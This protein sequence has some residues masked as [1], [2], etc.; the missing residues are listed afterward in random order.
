MKVVGAEAYSEYDDNKE[1]DTPAG[2]Q[3]HWQREHDAA[4]KRLRKYTNQGSRIVARYLGEKSGDGDNYGENREFQLN[5]FHSNIKTLTSMLYGNKPKIDV[6]REHH[7]PDD[8][9]GRVDAMLYQRILEADVAPSGDKISTVLKNVLQDRLLPGMGVARVRYDVQSEVQQALDPVTMQTT[10]SER[11]TG[12]FVPTDYICWQ[13]FSWGWGR[14]WTEVPWLGY[15][16]WMSKDESLARFGADKVRGLEYKNQMPSGDSNSEAISDPDQKN[17]VQKAEIWEFWDK[18]TKKVFW[19]SKGLSATLD[20]QD[21]PLEL[22]GFWP[23][24][25]PMIANVTTTLWS[26]KAD[27]ILAQDLYNEIDVL[28]TRISIITRAIKVVGVYDKNAGPSVGRMLKEGNENDL[29]PVDNWAMFAEKGG[30]KGQIDWFPVESIIGVLQILQGVRDQTISLLHQMTGMSDIMRGG[31]TDQYTSDGT[32]QLK[33]KFG[34]VGVQALQEDFAR[35]AS[36]LA[37]LKAEVISK[38]FSEESI[39]VQ[40][41]AEFVPQA[42]IDK[43][44]PAIA[45]MKSETIAWRVNIRPE[46]IAMI[47]YAQLK[48]ERTDYLMSMAQFV[49]SASGLIQSTPEALPVLLE[50]MK[51]GMAGFKGANYLEGTMDQAIEMA[52]NAPK[53][54]DEGA[55]KDKAKQEAEMQKFQLQMQLD[56]QKAQAAMGLEAQKAQASMQLENAKAQNSQQTIMAK[57]QA[58]SR[59]IMADLQADLELVQAKLQSE[60]KVEEAQSTFASAENVMAHE[61][62]MDEIGFAGEVALDQIDAQGENDEELAGGTELEDGDE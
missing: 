42:D 47:D 55:Q 35:F 40:S 52:K 29:I 31:N 49:Q 53:K 37:E 11:L 19:W 24:P 27:Y 7:D 61:G 54:E 58:D 30:L 57:Q 23:S 14:T 17:S 16:S 43:V 60:L 1:A 18:K 62:K 3:K 34:S 45:L 25:M 9:V 13:D 46:S 15:R 48:Q 10:A 6:G 2:W 32:Q 51:W 22:S 50:M 36:E 21:D 59:K 28:S 41:G 20:E 26:P 8:D 56:S 38:H 44:L 39:A 5:L 33:A 4:N 12:E